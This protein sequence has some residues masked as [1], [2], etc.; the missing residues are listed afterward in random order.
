MLLSP[1]NQSS[2][3][4]KEEKPWGQTVVLIANVRFPV[5]QSLKWQAL[6]LNNVSCSLQLFYFT[7]PKFL[8]SDLFICLLSDYEL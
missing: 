2:V 1:T 6:Q 8:G 3:S 4:K 7:I 5:L